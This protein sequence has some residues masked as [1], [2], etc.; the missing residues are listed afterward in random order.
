MFFQN[1]SFHSGLHGLYE[2]VLLYQQAGPILRWHVD[3]NGA[4]NDFK[5]KV[6]KT[7]DLHRN[8]VF[9]CM[10]PIDFVYRVLIRRPFTWGGW[11]KTVPLGLHLCLFGRPKLFFHS[12]KRLAAAIWLH[13][14]QKLLHHKTIANPP[15]TLSKYMTCVIMCQALFWNQPANIWNKQ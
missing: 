4:S 10:F 6:R 1:K 11:G 8:N 3:E 5:A 14:E 13:H 2:A 7:N 9:I 15:H 12:A